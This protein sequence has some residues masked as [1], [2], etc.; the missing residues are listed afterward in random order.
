M[1]MD[2]IRFSKPKSVHGSLLLKI[3]SSLY[4]KATAEIFNYKAIVVP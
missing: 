4:Y 1:N 2:C 3:S